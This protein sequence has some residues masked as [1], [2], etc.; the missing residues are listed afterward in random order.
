VFVQRAGVAALSLGEEPISAVKNK[1]RH[2]R[3]HL[4]SGLRDI[5]SLELSN[6]EGAMYLFIRVSNLKDSLSFTKELVRKHGLGLAPGQAFGPEGEGYVR[7]CFAT[8]ADRLELGLEK[9]K[10]I[11]QA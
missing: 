4:L 2:A 7:W 5:E 1:L 6:P 10:R 8:S 11:F 9:I 3:D